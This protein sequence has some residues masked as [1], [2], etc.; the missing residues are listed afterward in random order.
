M[1]D[2]IVGKVKSICDENQTKHPHLVTEF[3]SYTVGESG[4]ILYEVI[5]L[6]EQNEKELWYMINSSFIT[7]LP[8]TG[9][10]QQKFPLL[11][12]NHR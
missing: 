3:G 10:I 7:T 1:L 12:L 6:K 5:G 11:A 2:E 4:A 9:G 8:D